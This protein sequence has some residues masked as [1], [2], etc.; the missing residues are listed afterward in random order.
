MGIFGQQTNKRKCCLS[1]P[2]PFPISERL[3]LCNVRIP[4]FNNEFN[5]PIP[6]FNNPHSFQFMKHHYTTTP[7][8]PPLQSKTLCL[9]SRVCS[10]IP[11][12]PR[13]IGFPHIPTNTSTIAPLRSSWFCRRLQRS[14]TSLQFLLQLLPPQLIL[15]PL[16]H[17]TLL[18]TI[19]PLLPQYGGDSS[20]SRP[21]TNTPF[22]EIVACYLEML[23]GSHNVGARGSGLPVCSI[24]GF[25]TLR[26]LEGLGAVKMLDAKFGQEQRRRWKYALDDLELIK[27]ELFIR[28]L[29]ICSQIQFST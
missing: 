23:F 3:A 21:S 22:L 5:V 16:L 24:L 27:G 25:G 17:L 29:T 2:C 13:R 14:F 1:I 6:T 11:L 26:A 18:S 20:H 8:Q 10:G 28:F 12:D 19:L 9:F 7:Y 15:L 4:Q